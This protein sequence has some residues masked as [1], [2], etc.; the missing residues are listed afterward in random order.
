MENAGNPPNNNNP[1]HEEPPHNNPLYAN[2]PLHEYLHNPRIATPSCIMF[3]PNVQN[4]EFKLGMIQLL[5]TFHG[6]ERENPY[7]HIMEFREV[8]ATFQGRL[9]I[10]R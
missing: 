4:R 6:I 1:P 3:P 8:V 10:L 2:R 9:K 7:V 5:P